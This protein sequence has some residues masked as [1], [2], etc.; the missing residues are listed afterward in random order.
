MIWVNLEWAKGQLRQFIAMSEWKPRP[1]G[2]GR[3]AASREE[4]LQAAQVVEQI[5]D[6]VVPGW[7]NR[8]QGMF[9]DWT[10]HREAAHRALA[11]LERDQEI[12][13]NLGE[14]A[15]DLNAARMHSWAWEGARSLWE[16]AHYRAAVNA[17]A[18]KVSAETQNKVGRR[19]LSETKLFQ[20][21]FCL[22]PPEPGKPRLRLMA[23]DGSDTFKSLHE[24]VMAFAAGC[25][26]AIRNPAAH[27]LLPEL[28]E[29][30][31]LEQLVTFSLLAR[32][33]D[34]ATIDTV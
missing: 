22:K 34:V 25:Y 2:Y 10:V 5:L 31:A 27:A 33:V 12:R 17:A 28:D 16:S 9:D 1:G 7:K 8:Q 18:I 21:A 29:D 14:N 19:D 30:Q 3:N 26:K 4:L 11:Q 13:D 32:W 23:D 6:R 20:E 15:P 24:G